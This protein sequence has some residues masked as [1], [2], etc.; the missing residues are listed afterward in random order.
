MRQLRLGQLLLLLLYQQLAGVGLLLVSHAVVLAAEA[1]C[2]EAALELPVPC[3][4]H[5]VPFEVLG[6]GEPL[7]ALVAREP[8]LSHLFV[9]PLGRRRRAAGAGHPS[10]GCCCQR[11]LAATLLSGLHQA[12]AVVVAAAAPPVFMSVGQLLGGSCRFG[13]SAT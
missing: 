4:H 9:R 7:G 6:G 5:V 2:A 11:Q 13:S 8:L 10:T 1:V 3:V 12:E